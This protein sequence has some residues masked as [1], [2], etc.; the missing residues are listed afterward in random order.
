M[1]GQWAGWN[2]KEAGGVYGLGSVARTTESL[3]R[4]VPL[5]T[6]S[7]LNLVKTSETHVKGLTPED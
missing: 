5:Y 6:P 2:L 4:E 3:T 1:E 7:L